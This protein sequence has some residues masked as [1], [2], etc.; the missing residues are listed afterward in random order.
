MVICYAKSSNRIS[1]H[2]VKS[3]VLTVNS[4]VL[5]DLAPVIS[6]SSPPVA[7]LSYSFCIYCSRFLPQG[8]CTCYSQPEM[9]SPRYQLCNHNP[10]SFKSLLE[11]VNEDLPQCSSLIFL[12]CT[13]PFY[14]VVLN[15]AQPIFIYIAKCLYLPL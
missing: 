10:T 3:R 7:L 8:V 6:L 13:A 1:P 9:F 12:A 15:T 5:H 14:F 2:S 4:K 11:R